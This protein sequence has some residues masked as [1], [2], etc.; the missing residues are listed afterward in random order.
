MIIS[1]PDPHLILIQRP[2]VMS[3]MLKEK[4]RTQTK[5][6]N[7]ITNGLLAKIATGRKSS[8]KR[9][10]SSLFVYTNTRQTYAIQFL[11][12]GPKKLTKSE[13]FIHMDYSERE[14]QSAYFGQITFSIFTACCYLHNAKNK[15]ICE[16]LTITR[17]L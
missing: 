6:S 1:V 14:I 10:S 3:L 16:S 17:E 13:I 5:I 2:L 15:M 11:Q 12:Q 4:M 8:L 7:N 9:T